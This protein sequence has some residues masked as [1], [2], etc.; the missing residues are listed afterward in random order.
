MSS[1][2]N[3]IVIDCFGGS[4]VLAEVCIETKRDWI[5]IEKDEDYYNLSLKRVEDFLNSFSHET[6]NKDEE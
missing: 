6:S 2:E 3:N 1:N 5:V 4:G